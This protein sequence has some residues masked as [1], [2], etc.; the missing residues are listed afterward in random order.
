MKRI[1][2]LLAFTLATTPCLADD[3]PMAGKPWSTPASG[4]PF[5]TDKDQLQEYI[6]AALQKDEKWASSLDMCATVKGGLKVAVIED[7]P[8]SDIGHVVKARIFGTGGSAVG[9]TLSIG[10]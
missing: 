5:C 1:A 9:Y 2:A 10:L 6:M 7:L 8:G 4:Q 3:A